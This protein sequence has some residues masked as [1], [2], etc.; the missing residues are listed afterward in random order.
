MYIVKLNSTDGDNEDDLTKKMGTIPVEEHDISIQ[1]RTNVMLKAF[2]L[3]PHQVELLSLSGSFG[4]Y[5][6]GISDEEL[7]LIKE[8]LAT[9]PPNVKS[10]VM[11]LGWPYSCNSKQLPDILSAVPASITTLDIGLDRIF[12]KLKQSE[13]EDIDE[14]AEEAY[15]MLAA[16]PATVRILNLSTNH[17]QELNINIL[18]RLKGVLGQ[19]ETLYLSETELKAMT[20]EQ[21]KAVSEIFPN[22]KNVILTKRIPQDIFF[23]EIVEPDVRKGAN[24]ARTY[25]FKTEV[26][27]LLT[28]TAFFVQKNPEKVE[29][30]KTQLPEELNELVGKKTPGTN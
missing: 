6:A 10:L 5:P 8:A 7:E 2:P 25:G 22:V 20:V 26:Q 17:L 3:I 21:R 27:S 9:I 28:T 1:G 15:Q 4:S 11:R 23:D 30:D 29:L 12:L 19:V 16:I 14:L 24:L 18:E 13:T